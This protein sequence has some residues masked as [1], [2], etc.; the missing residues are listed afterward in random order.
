METSGWAASTMKGVNHS[1]N[2]PISVTVTPRLGFPVREGDTTPSI[3]C[4][5]A[6]QVF[7]LMVVWSMG[8]ATGACAGKVARD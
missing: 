7:A 6:L 5:I 8:P 3:F 2:A 4:G 1:T